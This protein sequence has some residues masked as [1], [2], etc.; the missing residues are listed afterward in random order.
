LTNENYIQAVASDIKQEVPPDV[1]PDGD[2]EDLFLLYAILA[3]TKGVSVTGRDVHD[4][5][6]A[7]MTNKDP[8]H[9]S[10]KPYDKL[11]PATR[12][13]DEPFVRAIRHVAA[14]LPGGST[15]SD[16]APKAD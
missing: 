8:N 9:E 10:I 15:H 11:A 2:S 1:L 13:E 3:L 12:Q 14:R 4:A 5:W 7:W 6:S 16:S